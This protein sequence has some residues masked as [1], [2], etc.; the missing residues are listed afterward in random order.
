MGGIGNRIQMCFVWKKE[1][2][3]EKREMSIVPLLF[4]REKKK[5]FRPRNP[6]LSGLL[7]IVLQFT[8]APKTQYV[9]AGGV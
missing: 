2:T 5:R 9:R 3:H 1:A 7:E 6:L 8:K 4:V